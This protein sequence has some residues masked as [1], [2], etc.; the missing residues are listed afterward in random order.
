MREG[1]FL[2][3]LIDR[4]GE[5]GG[6][7]DPLLA[8]VAQP[9]GA[10]AGR[11]LRRLRRRPAAAAGAPPHADR[12]A[13]AAHA[14]ARAPPTC[15]ASP[16][17]STRALDDVTTVARTC[18]PRSRATR[19]C[20]RRSSPTPRRARAHRPLRASAS[21]PATRGSCASTS[22][23]ARAPR[24]CSTAALRQT[25]AGDRGLRACTWRCTRAP[26]SARSR[27][28]R[29]PGFL[30]E[31]GLP[32]D[33]DAAAGALARGARADLHARPRLPDR[34]RPTTSSRCSRAGDARPGPGRAGR[35]RAQGRAG[36][37]SASG[38]ATGWRPRASSR[39]LARRA[40]AAAAAAGAR[41]RRA[42]AGGDRRV[43][44]LAA[45][46]EPGLGRDGGDGQPGARRRCCATWTPRGL[47][48]L[49]MNDLYW[50]FAAAASRRPDLA[51]ADRPRRGRRAAVGGAVGRG[52]HRAR[53]PSRSRA[54]STSTRRRPSGRRA[55][56]R[57]RFGLSAVHGTLR[58]G[59]D[60]G[61]R[62]PAVRP[63][64]RS[65]AST[66]SSCAATC[67]AAAEPEVI[68]LERPDDF[69]GARA[70]QRLRPEPEP[71][72][73]ALDRGR[74]AHRRST[75]SSA[76]CSAS[77]CGRRFATMAIGEMLPTPGPRA[78][79]RGGRRRASRSSR[80]SSTPRPHD[81]R[82]GLLAELEAHQAA[83]VR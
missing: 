35:H 82:H 71:V 73:R 46:R 34:A 22:A 61:A 21:W 27:G 54:A 48:D 83:A 64:R 40:G 58:G 66:T 72:H 56:V 70:R 3:P 23:G 55:V 41:R 45:R 13:P 15:R 12:R 10:G 80:R 44:R 42:D 68:V 50:P 52:G 18:S 7:D 60:R 81:R 78:Q 14:R 39:A 67:R 59:V 17:T 28:R 29:R 16:A 2:G 19:P 53:S 75:T 8:A 65:C 63:A 74:A 69:A 24:A 51:G 9:R 49:P 47:K 26:R 20:A 6:T 25:G 4:A 76:T 43:R 77:T 62:H 32:D 11:G 5:Y 36:A 1:A 31:F 38:P 37:S 79:R 33:G 30:A 57:N